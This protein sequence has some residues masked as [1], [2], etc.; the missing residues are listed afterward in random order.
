MVSFAD[1]KWQASGSM[2]VIHGNEANTATPD[3]ELEMIQGGVNECVL[4]AIG[5]TTLTGPSPNESG[6]DLGWAARQ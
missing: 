2:R 6:Q 5:I 4:L 1:E 3:K